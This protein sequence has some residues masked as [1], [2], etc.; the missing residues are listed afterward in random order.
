MK[1]V[2]LALQRGGPNGE[3]AFAWAISVVWPKPKPSHTVF[4]WQAFSISLLFQGS[5]LV[6]V[7]RFE[8]PCQPVPATVPYREAH[9]FQ[10]FVSYLRPPIGTRCQLLATSRRT[11]N[12]EELRTTRGRPQTRCSHQSS[13]G[14]PESAGAPTWHH[15]RPNH[16][17]L[18]RSAE[19]Q[20][21][22]YGN[23]QR[24]SVQRPRKR[25]WGVP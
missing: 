21:R 12:T 25:M 15:D 18:R 2:S 9:V 10:E 1:T 11:T 8:H 6:H 13:L 16:A 7:D 22:R 4:K 24:S 14:Y 5:Q 3:V 20:A 23:T 19:A 17:P